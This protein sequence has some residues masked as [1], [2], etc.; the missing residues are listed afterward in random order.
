MFE[1]IF[2]YSTPHWVRL[3]WRLLWLCFC[4]LKG[5]PFVWQKRWPDCGSWVLQQTSPSTESI[6]N[7]CRQR[8]IPVLS[9]DD[10]LYQLG[11]GCCRREFRPLLPLKHL[12]WLWIQP[13][14][15]ATEKLLKGSRSAGA[16][17]RVVST[18]E[19]LPAAGELGYP[20]VI[21]PCGNHGKGVVLDIKN[22]QELGTAFKLAKIHDQSDGGKIYQRQALPRSGHRWEDG[23]CSRGVSLLL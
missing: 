1:V 18:Q 19:A 5:I 9:L 22:E 13:T 8:G 2:E 6:L 17:R 7:A 14:I 3:H 15:R 11:Y 21:K 12:P 16:G 4:C 23:S 20:V 10:G